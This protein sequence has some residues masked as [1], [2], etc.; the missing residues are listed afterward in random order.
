M[1]EL[2]EVDFH[3]YCPECA[4]FNKSESEEPCIDCLSESHRVQTRKPVH[5]RKK[6]K[7]NKDSRRR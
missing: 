7:I 1:Y 4:H 3:G 5:F 6:L 2:K